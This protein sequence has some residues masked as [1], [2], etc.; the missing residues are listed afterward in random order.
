[1]LHG[2]ARTDEVRSH[3]SFAV[4]RLKSV[5]RAETRKQRRK[6]LKQ[7]RHPIAALPLTP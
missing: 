7:S 2:S 3:Q 6:Q 1:M 4:A 5:K